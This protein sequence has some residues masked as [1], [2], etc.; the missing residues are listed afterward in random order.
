MRKSDEEAAEVRGNQN[1]ET[2]AAELRDEGDGNHRMS[3]GYR[4]SQ[5]SQAAASSDEPMHGPGTK[6]IGQVLRD[7]AWK[8]PEGMTLK[9]KAK[10]TLECGKT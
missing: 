6:C 8:D 2:G 5:Q 1:E 4:G 10:E 3:D 7:L 9:I